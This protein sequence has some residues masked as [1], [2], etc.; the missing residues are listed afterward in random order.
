MRA[1]KEVRSMRSSR[2]LGWAFA[3]VVA[4]TLGAKADAKCCFTNPAYT[5]VCEAVPSEGESCQSILDY[6]NT[7]NS[8]GKSYCGGTTIRGGWQQSTCNSDARADVRPE[9]SGGAPSGADEEPA[10]RR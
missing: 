10:A 3:A 6:L 7:P 8:S 9:G 5:G 2:T 4:A 1:D